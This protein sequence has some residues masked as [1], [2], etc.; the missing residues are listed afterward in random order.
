M[1]NFQGI[2]ERSMGQTASPS[3]QNGL[4]TLV[5]AY[6]MFKD[7][8]WK[9]IFRTHFSPL[10]VPKRPI[11]QAIWDVPSAKRWRNGAQW[12]KTTCLSIANGPRSYLG[13]RVWDPL[14][15]PFWSQSGPF[16][17]HFGSFH[18]PNP[19]T[20]GSKWAKKNPFAHPK[21]SRTTFENNT[22]LTHF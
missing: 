19:V 15:T 17:T 12:A 4:K 11:F 16:P 8:F 3:A 22:F 9:Q 20:T 1:A 13:K 21:G 10:L 6:Q 5:L 2:L 7:H 14:L 18:G